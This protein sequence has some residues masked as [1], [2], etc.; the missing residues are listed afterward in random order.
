MLT[1]AT[2]LNIIRL[3][4]IREASGHKQITPVRV[5]EAHVVAEFFH[6]SPAQFQGIEPKT[7]QSLRRLLSEEW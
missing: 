4:R 6:S 7:L 5:S 3:L 2:T 1:P